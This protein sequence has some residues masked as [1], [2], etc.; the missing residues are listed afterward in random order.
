MFD[1]SNRR[2][3]PTLTRPFGRL[4][5][6]FFLSFGFLPTT[7]AGQATSSQPERFAE[8]RA[9][10]LETMAERNLPSVAVAVA[11]NG[12]IVWE[13]GF[14]WAD[15]ENRVAATPHTMYSLA[16][17]SKPIT[18]TG[19]MRLVQ[20]GQVGLDE[21]T[22]THLGLGKIRGLA[23]NA[24]GAT[25]RRV[26]SHTA[27]L[28][29]HYQFFYADEG[30]DR[31]TMDETISRY[32]ILVSAP[33][34]IY[35]YSNL[36]FG[37]LD[38]VIARVSGRTYTDYMRTEVFLPLGLTH[39]SINVPPE[40][41]PHAAVRYDAATKRPLP[42]YDF[43]HRG[44]SA[45]YSSAHDLVR[46]G[47]FHL[48]D[49]LPDQVQILS[50]NTREAM[51]EI[52]TPPQAARGYGLGW[53]VAQ[54]DHG[55]Y[56]VSHGGGMPGVSTRLVIYPEEDVALVVLC[57]TSDPSVSRIVQEVT[58]AALP[59]YG[60]A[61]REERAGQEEATAEEL[62][63]PDLS[64]F[65]GTWTGTLQ[66]WDTSIPMSMEVQEDGDVHVQVEGQLATLLTG[67]SFQ[68]GTLRGRFAGQIPTAD[69]RRHPHSVLLA[70]RQDGNMLRGAASAQTLEQPIHFALTSYVEVMRQR[71]R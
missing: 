70:L 47:M 4:W 28:P 48:G 13:E 33:G 56:G 52:H 46:F 24:A 20:E 42:G 18:A 71:N 35:A 17:I 63:R 59:G 62:A 37:I 3:G 12:E 38:H 10:I 49:N 55:Y 58:A 29:L 69:A 54:D 23:G 40:L 50:A 8:V 7:T 65:R 67:V 32:A 26:L 41:K 22:N 64:A 9:F 1:C 30:Y 21:P 68:G 25:V 2:T 45:V 11:D 16:S 15:K 34:E 14:G 5:G 19:L 53:V 6:F 39:T 61:L 57:N 27:G 66:T 36:G 51:W 31:P 60:E 43:D 44:A